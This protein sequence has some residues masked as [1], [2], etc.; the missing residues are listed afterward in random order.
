MLADTPNAGTLALLG[1]TWT[2]L[3]QARFVGPA[4]PE[5]LRG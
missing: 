5:R 1:R 2:P 4:A 3:S